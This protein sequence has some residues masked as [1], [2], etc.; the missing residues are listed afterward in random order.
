[1]K[2][3]ERE[4]SRPPR[5]SGRNPRQTPR[6]SLNLVHRRHR[7]RL[8]HIRERHRRKFRADPHHRRAKPLVEVLVDGRGD[9]GAGHRTSCTASWTMIAAPVFS[10]EASTVATSHGCTERRSITSHRMPSSA[11]LAA[12][13]LSVLDDPA[14]ADDRHVLA[15]ADDLGLADRNAAAAHRRIARVPQHGMFSMKITGSGSSMAL[16]IRP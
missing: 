14:I 5:S 10:T 4:P 2:S 11:S 13:A 6:R 7:S 12:W 9:L 1:M 15:L 16:R 3:G 8:Q